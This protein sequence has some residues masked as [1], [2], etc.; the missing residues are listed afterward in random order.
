MKTLIPGDSDSVNLVKN[1]KELL[2]HSRFLLR[3]VLAIPY[4]ETLRK[5]VCSFY[6]K[7]D[8]LPNNSAFALDLLEESSRLCCYIKHVKDRK[9]NVEK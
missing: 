4:I 2:K 1:R 5:G 6:K 9:E 7:L 3:Q 8:G